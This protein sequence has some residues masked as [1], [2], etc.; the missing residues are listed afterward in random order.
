MD[1]FGRLDRQTEAARWEAAATA[2][3][4][5]ATAQSLIGNT[6]NLY[7]QLGYLNERWLYRT[8]TCKVHKS[9]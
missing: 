1:L 9:F 3:D 4:L 6:A 5:Q 8:R 2:E 7:W